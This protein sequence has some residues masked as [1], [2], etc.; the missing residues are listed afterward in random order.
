VHSQVTHTTTR[1]SFVLL[2]TTV[3]FAP[4]LC[5]AQGCLK[6]VIIGDNKKPVAAA[7]VHLEKDDGLP[8][9]GPLHYVM[10]DA[11]GVFEFVDVVP[12]LYKIFADKESE[13]YPDDSF[14]FYSGSHVRR[15]EISDSPQCRN[16]T[17]SIS[18]GAT[19]NGA[20]HASAFPPPNHVTLILRRTDSTKAWLSTSIDSSFSILVPANTAFTIEAT[21]EGFQKWEWGKRQAIL[22]PPGKA[23][24]IVLEMKKGIASPPKSK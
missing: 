11:S 3:V 14:A 12:G 2:L 22:L 5:I 8:K 23:T 16:T 19:L 24:H 1:R 15:T 13:G 10:A 6:G 20:V 9:T 7:R 18:K 4:I 21:A 17:V